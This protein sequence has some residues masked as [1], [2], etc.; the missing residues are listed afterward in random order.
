MSGDV[1]RVAAAKCPECGHLALSWHKA[2][3]CA[4]HGFGPHR[5]PCV[6]SDAQALLAPGGAVA[7]MVAE[8]KRPDNFHAEVL[9][10]RA[11]QAERRV[12]RAESLADEWESRAA[13]ARSCAEARLGLSDAEGLRAHADL[14][15]RRAEELR[16]ALADPGVAA[17][18]PEPALGAPQEVGPVSVDP[19]D[20]LGPEIDTEGAE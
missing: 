17:R 15:Q 10:D 8:A 6:L 12:R 2:E 5:C 18:R 20:E 19:G 1:E 4:W 16:A 9:R 3:G 11:R 7:G 13:N 14:T